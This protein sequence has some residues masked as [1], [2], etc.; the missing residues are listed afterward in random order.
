MRL[1]DQIFIVAGILFLFSFSNGGS[2]FQKPLKVDRQPAV[3]GTF[4]PS[5][6]EVL[7]KLLAEY[8]TKAPA[9]LNQRPLAVIVPHAGYIFSGG[10]AAAGFKQID[11]NAVF[12]HVFVIGSSHTTNFDGASAY[13]TGD[14]IT[15]LGKV[16]VDT[17]AGWL[18]SKYSFIS[19]D[20]RPH[21]KNQIDR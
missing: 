1:F 17:L 20:T 2:N 18:V 11:R 6:R 3:A 8:F 4:Y 16:S 7:L 15:P 14:F 5:D 21:E 10:V 12:K 9:V 13:S 19:D